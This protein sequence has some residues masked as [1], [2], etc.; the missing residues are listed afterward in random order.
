MGV[1]K[2]SY[3]S[4]LAASLISML[5]ACG[6][7]DSGGSQGIDVEDPSNPQVE[8]GTTVQLDAAEL[9]DISA[10][11][12]YRWVQ[13]DGPAVTLNNAN[14]QVAS[15]IAPTVIAPNRAVLVFRLTVTDKFG[16]TN[17]DTV[18]RVTVVPVNVR[19]TVNAGSD[20]RV[21]EQTGVVL[22]GSAEDRDGTIVSFRW[23]QIEGPQVAL[24]G[25]NTRQGRDHRK[26]YCGATTTSA[27][28]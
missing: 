23:A 20:R 18:V 19:P 1:A 22:S 11:V 27:S 17:D 15:F 24:T 13:I 9:V 3:R 4:L 6:F 26:S 8:E 21:A 2:S 28:P 14:T 16:A 10:V 7:V 12:S 5:A 25:A